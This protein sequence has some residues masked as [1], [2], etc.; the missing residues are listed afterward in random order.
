MRRRSAFTLVEL[1]VA[2]TIIAILMAIL[3]PGFAAAR[4][5]ARMSAC[6]TNLHQIALALALYRQDAGELPP[7]LSAANADYVRA[8]QVFVCPSDGARGQ[9]AGSARMEG[10]LFLPTGVSYDYFPM[11]ETAQQLQWWAPAPDF[12]AGKWDELT[13]LIGCQ[14][15]WATTFNA[16]WRSNAQGVRGWQMIA[17]VQGSVRRARVEEPVE[18]FTPDRYR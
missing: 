2:I 10:T 17:T 16:S 8:P 9:H 6:S 12:G 18:T 11:W 1:M 5:R 7:H 3:L 4:S 15:H 13:P 14:W